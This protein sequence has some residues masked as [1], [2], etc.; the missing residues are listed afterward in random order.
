M[1]VIVFGFGVFVFKLCLASHVCCC[2]VRFVHESFLGNHVFCDFVCVLYDYCCVDRCLCSLI[3]FWL[4]Y[5]TFLYV[6]AR[7]KSKYVPRR[8]CLA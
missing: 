6:W 8:F 2:F 4:K 1:L 7:N 5:V 3:C